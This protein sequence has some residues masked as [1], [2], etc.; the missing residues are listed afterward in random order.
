[1]KEKVHHFTSPPASPRNS[2]PKES[3]SNHAGLLVVR[4]V[5]VVEGQPVLGPSA[6]AHHADAALAILPR[7]AVAL[8]VLGGA[9]LAVACSVDDN[10]EERDQKNDG[11]TISP[12][13]LSL[14]FSGCLANNALLEKHAKSCGFC[15]SRTSFDS[16]Q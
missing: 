2:T 1:M 4:E 7:N 11:E 9:L 6:T 5:A 3:R 15:S 14:S 10:G 13:S 12:L 16:A 8:G